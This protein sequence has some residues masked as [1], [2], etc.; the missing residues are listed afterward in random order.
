M[1]LFRRFP[2]VVLCKRPS[3]PLDFS[4]VNGIA[5][6]LHFYLSVLCVEAWHCWRREALWR[7]DVGE[8]HCES[9]KIDS[10]DGKMKPAHVQLSLMICSSDSWV[11][12]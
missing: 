5:N 10:V 3:R 2:I 7:R 6:P 4:T 11:K 1:N 9:N 8:F 12:W